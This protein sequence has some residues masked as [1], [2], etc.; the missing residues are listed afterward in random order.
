[1]V[2]ESPAELSQHSLV[3]SYAAKDHA[4]ISSRAIYCIAAALL[5]MFAPGASVCDGRME[6]YDDVFTAMEAVL[7]IEHSAS[8]DLLARMESLEPFAADASFLDSLATFI[9]N[10]LMLRTEVSLPEEI[11]AKAMRQGLRRINRLLHSRGRVD[12]DAVECEVLL[13]RAEEA[14]AMGA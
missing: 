5:S 11:P 14:T 1:M 7:E 4:P 13:A 6:H 2:S 8:L 10:L 3:G 12:P 9:T